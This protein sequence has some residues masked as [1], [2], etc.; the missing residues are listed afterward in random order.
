MSQTDN[1]AW[2]GIAKRIRTKWKKY[3]NFVTYGQSGQKTKGNTE[4]FFEEN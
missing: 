4:K 1:K 2:K 3:H